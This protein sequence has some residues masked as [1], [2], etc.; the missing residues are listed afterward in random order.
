ME[1]ARAL[2]LLTPRQRAAFVLVKVEGL[3]YR[4]AAEALGVPQG[5]VQSDVHAATL[6]LRAALSPA[7]GPAAPVPTKTVPKTEVIPHVAL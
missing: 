2:D 4:E 5:T 6:R 1:I 3:K 7:D